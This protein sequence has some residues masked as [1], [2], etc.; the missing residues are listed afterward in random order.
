MTAQL[1]IALISCLYS[2]AAVISSF[3]DVANLKLLL[4]IGLGVAASAIQFHSLRCFL[5]KTKHYTPRR[6]P[7]LVELSW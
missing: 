5:L 6:L 7:N 2:Q 3:H 1:P 4:G